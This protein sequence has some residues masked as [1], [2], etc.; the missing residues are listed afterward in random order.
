[1]VDAINGNYGVKPQDTSINWNDLTANEVL[2]YE[3]EGQDVPDEILAW[4]QDM[5]KTDNA[6]DVTYEMFETQESESSGNAAI[7]FREEMTGNKMNL[8][9]QGE[10]FIEES[11]NKENLTLQSITEMAPLLSAAQQIGNEA[12]AIGDETKTQLDA[13]KAQIDALINEKNDK[14]RFFQSRSERSEIQGLHAVAQALGANAQN[15]IGG[16]D[17]EIAEVDAIVNEAAF[18]SQ[19]SIDF[20]N[21]TTEIGNNLMDIKKSLISMG[22]G[23][24]N[25]SSPYFIFG[26]KRVGREAVEQ[27]ARTTA[28]GEQ[29]LEIAEQNAAVNGI[30]LDS[31]YQAT[32][33]IDD[34]PSNESST[35]DESNNSEETNNAENPDTADASNT[36]RR[37]GSTEEEL[38]PTLA[39]T[40]ITIDPDEILR[41]KERRGLA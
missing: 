22:Q 21:E 29:G 4:A 7:D 13:I 25:G 1:M 2:E 16:L 6:D 39:D 32:G 20:G 28:I 33:G 38:D 35:G 11:R 14:P 23:M 8:K 9:E 40:S 24:L 19:T 31:V 37:E 15:Q 34:T 41:R 36:S 26:G 17:A 27:G 3:E 10:A 12:V 30:A 18:N 5:A